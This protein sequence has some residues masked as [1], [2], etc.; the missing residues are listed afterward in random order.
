M[1]FR[2]GGGGAL[3]RIKGA[4]IKLFE[5][6]LGAYSNHNG[7]SYNFLFLQITYIAAMVMLTIKDFRAPNGEDHLVS[8]LPLSHIA[9]QVRKRHFYF[10]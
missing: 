9:A 1:P 6:Y 2:G 10:D 8:Y 4:L 7:M 3:N 5:V